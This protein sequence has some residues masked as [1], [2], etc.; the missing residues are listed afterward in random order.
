[1]L[2]VNPGCWA[3]K[4]KIMWLY[5]VKKNNRFARNTPIPSCSRSKGQLHRRLSALDSFWKH[6]QLKKNRSFKQSFL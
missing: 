1:M 4:N 3:V 2:Y 5:D 6:P